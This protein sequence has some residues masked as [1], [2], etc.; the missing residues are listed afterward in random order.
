MSTPPD[1]PGIPE[2]G[3]RPVQIAD[4]AASNLRTLK[5]MAIGVVT[6]GMGLVLYW[7]G[8][9]DDLARR[10]V[11]VEGKVIGRSVYSDNR[12]T[13]HDQLEF[14][15]RFKGYP[16][17]GMQNVSQSDYESH[18]VGTPVL[19]TVLPDSPD[20]V[21]YGQA[22]MER[23]TLIRVGGSLLVLMMSAMATANY[24]TTKRAIL[25]EKR[26]LSTWRAV[27]ARAT[28]VEV[29]PRTYTATLV[30]DYDVW[31]PEG[32]VAVQGQK[33]EVRENRVLRVGEAFPVLLDP[34]APRSSVLGPALSNVELKAI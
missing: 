17:T 5:G 10:G 6:V 34:D 16:Y 9:S 32:P 1:L 7:A 21:Q 28:R 20:E 27:P 30:V 13:Q 8:K 18:P 11:P 23:G 2:F 31:L 4:F 26:I 24:L 19:L 14:G 22:T 25:R 15:Y 33:V 29:T 3:P 12:G